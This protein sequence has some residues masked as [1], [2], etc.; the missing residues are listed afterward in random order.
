M[1][2]IWVKYYDFLKLSISKCL[3]WGGKKLTD[4]TKNTLTPKVV[5][6]SA[7]RL[8]SKELKVIGECLTRTNDVQLQVWANLKNKNK[9]KPILNIDNLWITL[10]WMD[11]QVQPWINRSQCVFSEVKYYGANP[12]RHLIYQ[13]STLQE[14][15]T[16]SN[17]VV[18]VHWT[19][20]LE[21]LIYCTVSGKFTRKLSMKPSLRE[22]VWI[23]GLFKYCCRAITKSDNLL[24]KIE[25]PHCWF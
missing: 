25:F 19:K 8:V 14:Y 3:R 11:S 6:K 24:K 2:K 23:S 10:S 7:S 5:V 21:P 1:D 16:L 20:S 22:T 4:T 9:K 17:R 13:R 15:L 18:V 12:W